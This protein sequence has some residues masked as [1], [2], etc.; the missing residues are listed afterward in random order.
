VLATGSQSWNYTIAPGKSQAFPEDRAW[1]VTYDRGAGH[2]QQ[3]YQLRSGQ[4][5][6]RQGPRGWEL[7]RSELEEAAPVVTAPPGVM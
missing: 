1:Q 3:T 6:F 7:Y 5:K 4:Y 2:G